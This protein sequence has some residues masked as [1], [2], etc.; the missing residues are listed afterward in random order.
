MATQSAPQELAGI[1]PKLVEVTNEVLFQDVWERPGLSPRD[2]SLVTV[3]VLAALYRSEQ[4]PYHLGVALDNGL[5][6]EELSEAITHLAFYAGWPNAM[7]AITLL[8]K[9]ADERSA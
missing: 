9:I 7:T 2:R 3:S 8:K 4:L 5:T 1:A 6:A